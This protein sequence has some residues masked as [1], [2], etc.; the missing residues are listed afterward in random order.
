MKIGTTT[1]F[2]TPAYYFVSAAQVYF[3]PD[4]GISWKDGIALQDKIIDLQ[5]GITYTMEEIR[6]QAITQDFIDPTIYIHE[7]WNELTIPSV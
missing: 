6:K 5:Y 3:T 2:P 1:I 7:V 4:G